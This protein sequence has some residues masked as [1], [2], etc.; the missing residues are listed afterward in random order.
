ML[1]NCCVCSCRKTSGF[2][3][4]PPGAAVVPGAGIPGLY[5]HHDVAFF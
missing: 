3:M 1:T 2:D 5:D 4:A